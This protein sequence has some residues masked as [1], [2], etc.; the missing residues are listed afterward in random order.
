MAEKEERPSSFLLLTR[1]LIPSSVFYPHD[2]VIAKGPRSEYPCTVVKVATYE[3][4]EVMNMQ[5]TPTVTFQDGKSSGEDNLMKVPSEF[6]TT[7]SMMVMTLKQ[8]VLA[9]SEN[10]E[11]AKEG[12]LLEQ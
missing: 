6:R 12:V 5:L 8:V 1:A 10:M 2:L 4:G 3:F 11:S 7:L 9:G